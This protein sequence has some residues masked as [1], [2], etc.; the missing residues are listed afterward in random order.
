MG[1]AQHP[2]ER[3]DMPRMVEVSG[4]QVEPDVRW[5]R[6]A[7]ARTNGGESARLMG[8]EVLSVSAG[9]RWPP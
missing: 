7:S 1:T 3:Q 6:S 4:V 5:R 9:E 8:P 2:L